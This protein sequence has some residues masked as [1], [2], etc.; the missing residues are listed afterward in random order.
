VNVMNLGETRLQLTKRVRAGIEKDKDNVIGLA[1]DIHAHPQLAYEENYAAGRISQYLERRGFEVQLGVY[2]MPTAFAATYGDGPLHLVFC[3][4][5]DALPPDA[6][7]DRMPAEFAEVIPVQTEKPKLN[8]H[9]CATTSL[10]AQRWPRQPV[11]RMSFRRSVYGCLCS[12]RRPRNSSGCQILQPAGSRQ[13]RQSS[14]MLAPSAMCMQRS[15]STRSQRRMERSSPP[16]P[17]AGS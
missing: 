10:P 17:T 1:H 12:A 13:E 3:A 14:F 7:S 16:T 2:D 8:V 6:L 15:W 9:A 5:Y 11:S 4:E